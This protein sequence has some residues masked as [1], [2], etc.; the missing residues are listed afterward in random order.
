MMAMLAIVA[1]VVYIFSRRQ[2]AIRMQPCSR[3]QLAK[4]RFF[5]PSKWEWKIF[6]LSLARW[7]TVVSKQQEAQIMFNNIFQQYFNN[8]STIFQWYF[9]NIFVNDIFVPGTVVNCGSR[10]QQYFQQYIFT[11]VS[12]QKAQIMFN[13][14]FAFSGQRKPAAPP[15]PE[16]IRKNEPPYTISNK[17]NCTK[18]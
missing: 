12:K 9:N 6:H 18:I 3:L 8:M 16:G 17:C 7:S 4:T 10:R 14:I 5:L 15:W 13:N 1:M 11:V 2:Y